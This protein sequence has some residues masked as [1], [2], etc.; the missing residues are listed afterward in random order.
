MSAAPRPH[1][2]E[3]EDGR[4]P[5]ADR[6]RGTDAAAPGADLP[7][8]ATPPDAVAR[9]RP[10]RAPSHRYT[11]FVSLMKVALPA[12]A[13][14]LVGAVALWPQLQDIGEDGFSI[15]FA[16]V[17]RDAAGAQRLVNARYYGTDADDQPFTITA[18]LAEETA[19]GSERLRLD[20]P[21]ADI[22][23]NDGAWIMLGADKGLYSQD[24]ETLDLSGTVNLFHDAGYELHTTAATIH[25]AE[26]RAVGDAPVRGQGP[27]GELTA[28]GF[29]LTDTGRRVEFTGRARLLLRP[30][31][32]PPPQQTRSPADGG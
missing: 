19:P 27:F 25:M 7:N 16:D 29:R 13:V 9:A 17:G 18:D 8:H 1:L 6:L 20:N 23:L 10:A 2:P 3:D 5:A 32:E 30:A 26:G 4:R 11:R 24:Q 31:P 14:A 22:T 15:S 21:K 12:V 28:E